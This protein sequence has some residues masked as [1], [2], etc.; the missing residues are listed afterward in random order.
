MNRGVARQRTFFDDEDRVDFGAQLANIHDRF[1]VQ[2]LAYCLLDN[3]YHLL[4][5]TPDGGLSEAMQHLGLVYTR[6]TNDRR[7]RDGPL[8]RGRYHSILVTTDRYLVIAARYIHRNALDVAG[9]TNPADYRWSSYRAYLGHRRVPAFLNTDLVL[10]QFGGDR[11]RLVRFTESEDPTVTT[12]ADL[13]PL[14]ECSVARD[15]LANG[16]DSPRRWTA[17]TV[18]VGIAASGVGPLGL[19][20][21]IERHLAFPTPKARTQAFTRFACTPLDPAAARV[22]AAITAV[23]SCH[24]ARR[25]GRKSV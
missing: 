14:I 9:V 13:L 15:D 11:A 16:D 22:L 5:R 8:F 1:G 17:R 4:L 24:G 2:T 7:G 19:R 23:L 18:L 20:D 21:E 12:L 3:H 10:D 25:H 6:H